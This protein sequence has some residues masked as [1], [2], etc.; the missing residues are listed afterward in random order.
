MFSI[1]NKVVCINKSYA[2][3]FNLHKKEYTIIGNSDTRISRNEIDYIVLENEHFA[4]NSKFFMTITNYRKLKLEK[5][6]VTLR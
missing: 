2:K 4:F 1:G 5:L 6:N 3:K